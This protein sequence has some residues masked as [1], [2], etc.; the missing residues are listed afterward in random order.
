VD[1]LIKWFGSCEHKLV[2]SCFYATPMLVIER[3]GFG[4]SMRLTPSSPVSVEIGV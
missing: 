4:I 2:L 1:L 3:K